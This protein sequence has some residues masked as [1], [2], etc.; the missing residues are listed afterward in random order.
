MRL[1]HKLYTN[2]ENIS[3]PLFVK[4]NIFIERVRERKNTLIVF[5]FMESSVV[6]RIGY[7]IICFRAF[8]LIGTYQSVHSYFD[9][10]NTKSSLEL[11]YNTGWIDIF[12]V[13]LV[14]S[15]NNMP[16]K[17][18]AITKDRFF[19]C[20]ISDASEKKRFSKIVCVILTAHDEKISMSNKSWCHCLQVTY[21]QY[22]CGT[23]WQIRLI[24]RIFRTKT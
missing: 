3:F 15:A 21:Q 19:H 2:Y 18:Q 4:I 17:W 10:C 23:L 5:I 12:A 16:I 11:A 24:H 6:I 20:C 9:S 22:E 13:R 1:Q 8:T 14:Q 7:A